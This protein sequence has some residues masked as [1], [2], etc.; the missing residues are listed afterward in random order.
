MQVCLNYNT[1]IK[2]VLYASICPGI[3]R[4]K[5]DQKVKTEKSEANM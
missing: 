3:V 1:S 4:W 2:Y 5:R